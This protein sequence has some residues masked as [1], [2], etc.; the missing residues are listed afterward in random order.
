[1]VTWEEAKLR[2][3]IRKCDDGVEE[4]NKELKQ[5]LKDGKNRVNIKYIHGYNCKEYTSTCYSILKGIL[6]I[7]KFTTSYFLPYIKSIYPLWISLCPYS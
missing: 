4:M 2:K 3:Y 1:M 7:C 5:G 6:K